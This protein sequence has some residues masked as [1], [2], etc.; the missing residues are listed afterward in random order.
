MLVWSV[1]TIDLMK[2]IFLW[3]MPVVTVAAILTLLLDKKKG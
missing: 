2:G 1:V 3:A